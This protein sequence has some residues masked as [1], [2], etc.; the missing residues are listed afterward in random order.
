MIGAFLILGKDDCP[1]CEKAEDL[2]IE[3]G[4]GVLYED[5]YDHP[6]YLSLLKMA[7]LKTVPQVF[8]PSGKHIGGYEELVMHINNLDIYQ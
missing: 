8:S 3:T 2:L 1:W 5:I 6:H 7:G 4:L